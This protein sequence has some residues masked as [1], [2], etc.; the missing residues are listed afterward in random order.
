M[1]TQT[2]V[3]QGT[4]QRHNVEYRISL[5][6]PRHMTHVMKESIEDAIYAQ[7]RREP[8]FGYAYFCDDHSL[9]VG[10]QTDKPRTH[11]KVLKMILHLLAQAGLHEPGPGLNTKVPGLT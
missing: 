6:V 10:A 3:S 2:F 5:N 7:L 9:V 8:G 1:G 4:T 11:V